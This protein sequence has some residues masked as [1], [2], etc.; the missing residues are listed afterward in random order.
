MRE[1]LRDFVEDAHWQGIKDDLVDAAG[2]ALRAGLASSTEP[3]H[4]YHFTDCDGLVSIFQSRSLWASLA[5]ALNDESEVRYGVTR[6]RN[7]LKNGAFSAG[8]AF[9]A[10]VEHFLDLKNP[11]LTMGLEFEAC[12]AY[13]ISFCA[14]VDSSL[15]W[16]HYGRSGRGFAIAFDTRG[17]KRSPFELAPVIYDEARQ[18]RFLGSI[19]ESVWN[20]LQGHNLGDPASKISSVLFNVAAHSTAVHI[21]LAAPIL[22]NPAFASE[23]EWRLIT[24]DI[25][26]RKGKPRPEEVAL[27]RRFRV[28]A[29]RIVPY[30]EYSLKELPVTELVL[31][32]DVPMVPEDPGL[33]ILLHE[34]MKEKSL[35]VLRSSVPLRS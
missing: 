29:G 23:E 26:R 13:V 12:D 17:L 7:L 27:P 31:G 32:A 34:T 5:T 21:W 6:A 1:L 30:Y 4:L 9:L 14:R 8:P 24:Y 16:L 15:H 22:K 11:P 20:C 2:R 10:K 28:V 33:A 35:K 3:P 19:V 18:D 25:R